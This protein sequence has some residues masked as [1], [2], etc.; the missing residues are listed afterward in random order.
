MSIEADIFRLSFGLL[1]GIILPRVP[2]L[3]FT[4]FLNLERNLPPHPDP[5]PV[6]KHLVLRLLLMRRVHIM[7]WI[8]ALLPLSLGVLILN[9]HLNHLPLA[10]LRAWLGL[11]F[12]DVFLSKS[13]EDL[14][15]CHF[16]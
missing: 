15:C 6:D 7:C 2:L 5:I 1:L 4:R 14:G 12:L 13:K 9:H 10:W 11:P 16:H 3:F 8:I